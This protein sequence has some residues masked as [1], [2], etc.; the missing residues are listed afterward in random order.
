MARARWIAA[1]SLL[2]RARRALADPF[3]KAEIF[4]KDAEALRCLGRFRASFSCYSSAYKLYR[5]LSVSAECLA[6]LLGMSACLRVLGRYDAAREMW[7]RGLD[8]QRNLLPGGKGS[9]FSPQVELERALVARGLGRFSETRFRID[10]ALRTLKQQKPGSGRSDLQHAHW[11]SGGLARF[12]GFFPKALVSF[13]EAARLARQSGDESAEAFALCGLAGVQRI[14]GNDRSSL[15][16]Y[17]KAHHLLKR[18]GDPFG[19]A[20]GLCGQANALRTFGNASRS[21]PLYLRSA[22]L[23]R[24]LGDESSEAFAHWGRGGSYRRLRRFSAA[25]ESYKTALRLFKKSKDDRG[26]V[27]AH[28]GLARV[29]ESCGQTREAI[30]Q[31]GVGLAVARRAKLRY[32]TALSHY[33]M[34]RIRNPVRPPHFLLKSMGLSPSVLRRWRDIP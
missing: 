28:L 29:A 10:R 3:L 14:M 30:R 21:L 33:E 31:A 25:Q 6:T 23:Y 16:N 9:L 27:M 2:V 8:A 19:E 34:R 13:G 22:A 26:L 12:T 11:I 20:Y 32:E 15:S 1:H 17:Q 4:H 24:R 5:K 18:M 7:T